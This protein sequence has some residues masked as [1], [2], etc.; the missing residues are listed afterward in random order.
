LEEKMNIFYV[1]EDPVVAAQSLCDKHVV[2][3]I[4]ESAQLLSTAH[5]LLDG[6]EVDALTKTGRKTKRW[7]LPDSR[8]GIVYSATHRNHP[9]AIWCRQSLENYGW[10]A[11]HLHAMLNEYTYRYGKKHKTDEMA[12]YIYSPPYN[13][14]DWDFTPMPS[15]MATE[16]IIS[17]DPVVNYRNYYIHGKKHLHKWTKRTPPEWLYENATGPH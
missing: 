2:K 16:Y 12:Y 5:R 8:D 11:S 13:L 10:L 1:H 17:K 14:R 9:S 15:C 6:T 3:M 7:L 4:L